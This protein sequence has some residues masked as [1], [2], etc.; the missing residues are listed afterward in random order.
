MRS[1]QISRPI[2]IKNGSMVSIT[3][4]FQ[5][6]IEHLLAHKKRYGRILALG[7]NGH[8]LSHA[9]PEV[10]LRLQNQLRLHVFIALRSSKEIGV[11]TV[12]LQKLL[13][14]DYDYA[15]AI[16]IVGSEIVA[17][18]SGPQMRF[19]PHGA[20]ILE[21]LRGTLFANSLAGKMP[22]T[23]LFIGR[24]FERS[25][26]FLDLELKRCKTTVD[27]FLGSQQPRHA[28]VGNMLLA[29]VYNQAHVFAVN[30]DLI[31]AFLLIDDIT[32]PW[33]RITIGSQ[34]IEEIGVIDGVHDKV[35]L[36]FGKGKFRFMPFLVRFRNNFELTAIR[37]EGILLEEVAG[38]H[39]P[40]T[41]L[42]L[43]TERV[44]L[45][46]GEQQ[47]LEFQSTTRV[48]DRFSQMMTA[49]SSDRYSLTA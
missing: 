37:V 42:S 18:I 41:R 46:C 16:G 25:L 36:T 40:V 48:G 7:Q 26:T 2:G 6:V 11:A 9:D 30:A 15:H 34:Q 33:Q 31:S 13:L 22:E 19:N 5:D 38:V 1:L 32:L 21:T 20:F 4:P 23:V 47:V 45:V 44:V 28:I 12:I 29:A 14:E 35:L 39:R 3:G 24:P 10:Q 43:K 27:P 17:L 49:V 8:L